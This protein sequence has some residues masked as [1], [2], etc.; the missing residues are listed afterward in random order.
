M[1]VETLNYRIIVMLAVIFSCLMAISSVCA[2]ENTTDDIKTIIMD[3][4]VTISIN[5]SRASFSEL[6]SEIAGVDDGGVFNLSRDYE[7]AD[8]SPNGIV[9][10]KPITINGNGHVL[11][12]TNRARIFNVTSDNVTLKN[13]TFTNGGQVNLGGAVYSGNGNLTITNSVFIN[14]SAIVSGGAV[15]LK[16]ESFKNT[17]VNCSFENNCANTSGGAFEGYLCQV[18]LENVKFTNNNASQGAGAALQ[19]SMAVF[20]DCTFNGNVAER[21][22][23]ALYAYYSITSVEGC[24]V[25]DN[26]VIGKYPFAG[27]IAY[28]G[29][30][31]LIFDSLIC[32]NSITGDYGYASSIYNY[33]RL[34]ITDSV[35]SD[36]RQKTR[37]AVNQTVVTTSG[38]VSCINVTFENNS[39]ESDNESVIYTL[40]WPLVYGE[41]FDPATE[42]PSSL[43]LRT[44]TYANGTVEE[45]FKPIQNQGKSGGCWAFSATS[46][47]EYYFKSHYDK[48]YE[49]SEN[50][51]INIMG[52]YA[53]DGWTLQKGGATAKAVAYWARWSGPVNS[54]EDPFNDSSRYSPDNLTVMGH[55]QDVIYITCGDVTQIKLAIIEYGPV[56]VGYKYYD[57]KVFIQ[58]GTYLES[59]DS[60]INLFPR[61]SSHLVSIVGWNDTYPGSRFGEGI[62]DGA[63][64]IRNSF[65]DRFF[66]DTLNETVYLEGGGYN[67]ISYYDL[68]LST[69]SIA[70]AIVN[71]EATDNY[72]RNYQY[73]TKGT[74]ISMGYN[75][76]TAWFANQFTAAD[77][78]PLAAFSLY[79]FAINS[80]YDASI[81]VNG[82]LAYTQNASISN[83]G[84]HTIAL[85]ELV[86]LN[87]N[88]IFRIEVKLT[89]PGFAYPIALETAD[90]SMITKTSADLNQS[91]VSPDGINWYDIS[92]T[93]EVL[94]MELGSLSYRKM[95][96]T[97][98]CIK[99]FTVRLNT[100]VSAASVTTQYNGGKYLTVTLMDS[101]MRPISK[102]K[103]TVALNGKT[104]TLTTDSKGQVRISTDG[105]KVKTY[106]ATLSFRGDA[107]YAGS[108]SNAKI[109]VKKATPKLKAAKRTFKKSLKIKKYTVTLKSNRNKALKSRWVTLKVNKKIYRAKTNK[110]GKATFKITGLKKKGRFVAAV[111]YAGNSYYKAKMVK[112]K[113]TVR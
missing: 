7:Y 91:F 89:C 96:D 68:T 52:V 45:Q 11:D 86:D 112:S 56:V 50:N 75:S 77:N 84:Y 63:F 109:T 87:R 90:S 19:H 31:N 18:L 14:N 55:L 4:D 47:M 66:N 70:Y 39:V 110:Y 33:G 107:S 108:T 35:I 106:V 67:W 88:D 23:G 113:I 54:S 48:M 25:R 74:L 32:N 42:I 105:L 13:I 53:K 69:E 80:T 46:I 97:N 40:F 9:I 6:E 17:I 44:I 21:S 81:Y 85:D 26:R 22:A 51:L 111:R 95:N 79:T 72:N 36:N 10:S 76:D 73:D 3:D 1:E 58:N 29:F 102:K 27:A 57:P 78:S 65:S 2:A 41:I 34:S 59:M 99:A 62:P 38:T 103:I 37:N 93:T 61:Y 49:F 12:A 98:V 60:P 16:G 100:T 20:A 83:P 8:S 24:V 92:Q 82:K 94:Y 30:D 71:V 101:K 15:Y 64:L 43:D 104:K 5:T 28:F